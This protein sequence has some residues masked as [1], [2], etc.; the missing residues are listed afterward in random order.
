MGMMSIVP[1]CNPCSL[2]CHRLLSCRKRCCIL[3][4]Q[5]PACMYIWTVIIVMSLTNKSFVWLGRMQY[6]E[7]GGLSKCILVYIGLSM[8]C[9]CRSL[10]H[11]SSQV[12]THKSFPAKPGKGSH[13]AL[14]ASCN[15]TWQQGGEEGRHEGVQLRQHSPKGPPGSLR[16]RPWAP[17]L[18]PRT[19]VLPIVG[20]LMALVVV[21]LLVLLEAQQALDGLPDRRHPRKVQDQGPR[22]DQQEAPRRTVLHVHTDVTEQAWNKT[23]E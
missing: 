1:I 3:W 16:G 4:I 17:M 11:F 15:P 20:L 13:R 10:V 22:H 6:K 21:G 9:C 12:R 8:R 19:L 14:R 5:V 23:A 2:S 18:P 7:H